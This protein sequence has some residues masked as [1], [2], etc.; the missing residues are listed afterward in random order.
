MLPK[1]KV[2]KCEILKFMYKT[3]K[4]QFVKCVK[5]TED[6]CIWNCKHCMVYEIIKIANSFPLGIYIILDEMEKKIQINKSIIG[7]IVRTDKK[8]KER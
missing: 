8:Q 6:S 5:N 7:H 1:V 4:P 3:I 2:S